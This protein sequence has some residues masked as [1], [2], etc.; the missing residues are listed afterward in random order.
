MYSSQ[1]HTEGIFGYINSFD[2][3][4][5]YVTWTTDGAN[6]GTVFYRN[7]RFN[8]T[9]VCGTLKS[10]SDQVVMR[11]LAL[12]LGGI[13]KNH[14]IELGNPKLMNNVVQS[15]EIPL[16][17]LMLQKEIV[18]EIEGYQKV[19]DGVRSV[20][21]NYRPHI[22]IHPDWPM[23]AIA[24]IAEEIRAGFACGNAVVNTDGVPH[25]RPMNVT[26]CGKFTGD[27]M[28]RISEEEFR[29]KEDYGLAPGD[30]LFNNTNSKELVGKTCLITEE[31][32]G[33]YSNHMTRIRIARQLC[34]AHFLAVSLHAAWRRGEFLER[35]NRWVGQ[36]GINLKSL[37]EF[38]IPLPPLSTQQ[39]IIAE[40]E[41]EQSLVNANTEL[42]TRFEKKIQATIARVWGEDEPAP[43]EV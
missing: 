28:K 2:F 13:A 19:I 18:A 43:V 24:D 20:L 30:V 10:K 15:I 25:V 8:C 35:A 37:G 17:P 12:A 33:G 26:E 7:G 9:N 39:A 40:I 41:A 22:P 42:I 31:I 4:G 6:A 32:R 1:T 3:E 23:V 38:M 21:D 16:P 14:V 27:G 5:E 34:D 29:G 36:A 11:Y